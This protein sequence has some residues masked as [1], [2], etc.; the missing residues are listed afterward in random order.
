MYRRDIRVNGEFYV[1]SCVNELLEMGLKVKVFEIDHYIGWGT[2]NDY[3][4]YKYWQSFFHKVDWHPYRLEKDVTVNQDAL[5]DLEKEYA[6]FR[7]E[8]R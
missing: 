1:D 8:W 4:T 6:Q 7:Q 2:P 5:D 3:Q